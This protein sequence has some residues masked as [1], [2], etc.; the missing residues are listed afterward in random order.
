VAWAG[1]QSAFAF[2]GLTFVASVLCLLAMPR[3]VP[4]T[5]QP[6]ANSPTT[7][8]ETGTASSGL[9]RMLYDL[10]EGLRYVTR[11]TWLWVTIAV[12]SIANVG[13]TGAFIVA[14]P[15]LVHDFYHGDVWLLGLIGTTNAIGSIVATLVVCHAKRLR[16]RG[17]LAYG[18]MAVGS[19]ALAAFGLPWSPHVAPIAACTLSA[20]IGLGS[21][22][23]DIVWTT[24]LQEMVPRDTLGRVSSIDW[25][26]SLLMTPL[27]FAAAGTLT[28][29]IGPARVFIAAGILNLAANLAGLGVRGV[30]ELD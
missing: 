16:H 17:W 8:V 15:K 25:V 23:F 22:T 20:I 14:A 4:A 29:R 24:T 11:S 19:V 2:D 10:G 21:G 12:A 27:G 5:S 6:P 26:G 1:V 30:R 9:R 7:S 28:D 13:W 18:P 3:A